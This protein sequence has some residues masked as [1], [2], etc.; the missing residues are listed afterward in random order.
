MTYQSG[1][2]FKQMTRCVILMEKR[3]GFI[4][5]LL[6]LLCVTWHSLFP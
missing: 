2:T 3:V 6:W 1:S 5:L 4:S